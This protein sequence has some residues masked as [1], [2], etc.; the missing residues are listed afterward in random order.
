MLRRMH[1]IRSLTILAYCFLASTAAAAALHTGE[2]AQWRIVLP[3]DATAAERYAAE[4]LRGLLE[5]TTGLAPAI[6]DADRGG[7]RVIFVGAGAA[8]QRHYRDW[9]PESH[10]PEGFRIVIADEHIAIAG[11]RPRGTLYGVYEF[12]ERYL[13]VRFLTASHT[14]VPLDPIRALPHSDFAYEPPFDFRWAYW[15][16]IN[17]TPAFAARLRNNVTTH[18]AILGGSTDQPLI[19]HTIQEQVPAA[20]WGASN[21]EY[22]A[23]VDGE[24]TLQA[25]HA[26]QVDPLNP[27][28]Q[29]LVT[30][31]VR[32][33]LR[34]HP[35]RRV[36]SVSPADNGD[37]DESWASL[38][39]IEREGTPMAPHLTLV[40]EVA[41]RIRAEFPEAMVGT[42]AYWSTRKPPRTMRPASNVQIQLASFECSLVHALDDPSS[43]AN[44]AFMDDLD[45]WLALTNEVYLWH[46][47]A[48]LGQVDV[49]I[50][51]FDT[52]APS[53]RMLRD[54]GVKGVFSQ[55]NGRCNAGEFSDL[56]AYLVSR[57][58]WNPDLDAEELVAEFLDLHYGPAATHLEA[59]IALLADAHAAQGGE[60]MCYPFVE[61]LG[62]TPTVAYDFAQHLDDAHAAVEGTPYA[63]RVEKL[64][65]MGLKARLVANA[66]WTH[67]AERAFLAVPGE[68]DG[69]LDEYRALT[70]RFGM[71]RNMEFE[72]LSNYLRMLA[73]RREG[74]PI[75]TLENDAWLLVAV[76]SE[77]AVFRLL[78]KPT[79]HEVLPA[80]GSPGVRLLHGTFAAYGVTGFDG[81][82][83]PMEVER[84]PHGLVLS[85]TPD[86]GLHLEWELALE[87]IPPHR[88]LSQVTVT[89]AGDD[90]RP[91]R[92]HVD[93]E[94]A[95][96]HANA[97]AFSVL[98]EGWQ[99]VTLDPHPRTASPRANDGGVRLD[100]FAPSKALELLYD[101]G[102]AQPVLSWSPGLREAGVR[103]RSQR[104]PMSPGGHFSLRFVVSVEP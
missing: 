90:T 103:L 52:F 5:S 67:D 22:F 68:F 37:Y 6:S 57:L 51:N 47:A 53:F 74:V 2:I 48:N 80:Y 43:P 15:H 46:Y 59:A 66:V 58:L 34:Q 42:L 7:S 88:V 19:S 94:T 17:E 4:E 100:A 104:V 55:G 64:R 20:E 31:A 21:P 93:L 3:A 40:N 9:T 44:A 95:W 18:A 96:P 25:R 45:G 13:G 50:A 54:R 26:P 86:N 24:R 28:V 16:E 98:N 12:A 82:T 8:L 11:G 30:E 92:L 84:V 77:G 75:E 63:S 1:A 69:W 10:G 23:W 60:P 81:R 36:V 56:K 101:A 65:I 78:H 49:P 39:L 70:E 79:G 97:P 27:A 41:R 61:E 71:N 35:G 76:P 38:A 87:P 33:E 62:I 91:A 72:P 32:A 89:T 29:D 73:E 102:Q 14:H 85:H 99:Q 83:A